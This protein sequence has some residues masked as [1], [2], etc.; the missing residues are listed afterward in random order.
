MSTRSSNPD[1]IPGLEPTRRGNGGGSNRLQSRREPENSETHM[2]DFIHRAA[3]EVY[4][5]VYGGFAEL[6][7]DKIL[8]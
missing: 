4:R 1:L 5:E 8:G 7:E 3:P 6:A 2:I